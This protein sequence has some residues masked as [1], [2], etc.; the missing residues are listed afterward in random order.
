MKKSLL[1]FLIFI[2]LL[3][4]AVS[5]FLSNNSKNQSQ[6]IDNQLDLSQPITTPTTSSPSAITKPNQEETMAQLVTIKT[7][8]GDITLKL[9]ED[10]APNTVKNFTTKAESGFYENLN[11]HRV[12]DWVIQGGDPLGNGTGGGQME[13]ELNDLPFVEGSLG[14][15]R[16]GDISISND[17]QFFICTK[18]CSWLNQQY[19]NFGLVTDGMDVVKKIQINDKILSISTQ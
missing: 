8:K 12:E 6:T 3:V 17:S 18:D 10:K 16:G 7:S 13:T 4:I 1:I 9:F 11:F 5:I 15:A 19:T 2:V 14:V